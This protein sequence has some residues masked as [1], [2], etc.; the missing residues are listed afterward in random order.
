MSSIDIDVFLVTCGYT[1]MKQKGTSN[2]RHP[3][4]GLR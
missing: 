3:F 1:F 4:L 2:E